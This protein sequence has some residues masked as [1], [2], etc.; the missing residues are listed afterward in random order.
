MRRI[1]NVLARITEYPISHL[2]RT[3]VQTGSRHNLGLSDSD[4]IKSFISSALFL[5]IKDVYPKLT[6]SFIAFQAFSGSLGQN[7]EK[8]AWILNS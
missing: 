4:S 6:G 5:Q 2:Q 3:E 7:W 1:H 8:F